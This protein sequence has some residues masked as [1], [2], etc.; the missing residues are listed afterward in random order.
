MQI[1]VINVPLFWFQLKK[2][3]IE[4]SKEGTLKPVST[5]GDAAKP[6]PKK[7]GRWDQTGDGEVIPA[8]KKDLGWDKEE[9]SYIIMK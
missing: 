1:I 6:A 5:N 9:V 7:R 4:K 8:K 2:K 3:L